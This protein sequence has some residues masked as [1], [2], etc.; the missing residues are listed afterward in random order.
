MMTMISQPEDHIVEMANKSLTKPDDF[1]YW[2][3]ADL[4][5][6]WGWAGIDFN[7]DSGVLDRSNYQAFW[8]DV[9]PL[10][11]DSF[12]SEQMNH[13]AVGWVERTLVQVLH[14]DVDGVIYTNIT[15]AFCETLSV[16][17]SLSDYPVL[18]D[19]LYSEM[20]W[21]ENIRIIEEYAPEMIDRNVEGWSEKLLSSLL[22]NDVEMC[23][24]ADCY[25]SEEEMKEAAYSYG[26]CSKHH[27]EEWL[28]YCFDNNLT[29]P[30][31][32]KPKETV[33]QLGM[34]F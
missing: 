13:W 28:E 25:P 9:V 8:R 7:R 30:S 21:E 18:D 4:F 34:G 32:F 29:K 20:E 22:D 14:N 2:G 10:H 33:G 31:I 17:E 11:K 23:P 12:L 24:D 27:E 19:A 5:N 16:L 15:E 3:N 26:L 6:T 1:G